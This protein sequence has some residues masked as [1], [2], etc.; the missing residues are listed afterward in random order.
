MKI[1]R[2]ESKIQR[3]MAIGYI[4]NKIGE[5]L[6]RLPE[7][8]LEAVCMALWVDISKLSDRHLK[9]IED[10]EDKIEL[11]ELLASIAEALERTW[12]DIVAMNLEYA[13]AMYILH[14]RRTVQERT[15]ADKSLPPSVE[16]AIETGFKSIVA[17]SNLLR[18]LEK[19][20]K[21]HKRITFKVKDRLKIALKLI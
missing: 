11:E 2:F 13:I 8:K 3:L 1:N 7:W 20:P 9:K 17:I 15:F 5:R 4:S 6:L 14:L 16:G 19:V 10:T 12:L 21:V 18:N